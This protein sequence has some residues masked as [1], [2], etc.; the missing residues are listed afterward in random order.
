MIYYFSEKK[1]TMKHLPFFIL[2]IAVCL[3]CTGIKNKNKTIALIPQPRSVVT[4]QGFFRLKNTAAVYSA[5]PSVSPVIDVFAEEVKDYIPVSKSDGSAGKIEIKIVSGMPDEAYSLNVSKDRITVSATTTSGVFYGLQTLRQLIIFPEN[6]NGSI[7]IPCMTIND[8]PEFGWRGIMLDESRHFFGTETVKQ[9][10][11]MMALHKL[12]T[13]HWHLTDVQGWRIE[14]RKYPLLTITGGIGNLSDQ[15]APAKFYTQDQIKEIVKYAKE[16][17]IRI[18]P[19][20]DMPG[21]AGASN[22]AYPEYSGGGSE[23]YPEFTFDPG[24]EITYA[25]LTN[26]LREVKELFPAPYIHL[27]GDEVSFG[28][29]KWPGNPGIKALMKKH[30][31]K[32]MVDVEKYFV[33]RMSDSINSLGRMTIGWDEITSAG[34]DTAAAVVMWWRH[35]KPE[36]LR[37]ALESGYKVI[38][39]PRIPLY[40]DFVQDSVYKIGRRWKGAFCKPETVYNFPPD[41]LPGFNAHRKQILGMQANLW[42]ELIGDNKRLDFMIYPRLS[43][44]AEASWTSKDKKEYNSFLERLKPMLGYM[45]S[46]GIYYFDPFDPQATPEPPAPVRKQ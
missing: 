5:D 16:R 4:E 3:S 1:P 44:L 26:I 42:T 31:Y 19:E 24:K 21:H 2:I 35:D 22:R 25:Y 20:I 41:T 40:F 23:R 18:I 7:L 45:K 30:N 15:N 6:K 29:E 37:A 10:L 14:I 39:C 27:G 8:R 38:M 13:F 9:L 32:D 28:N 34:M 43:A 11:D 17:F 33:R 12:N 46:K 36:Q